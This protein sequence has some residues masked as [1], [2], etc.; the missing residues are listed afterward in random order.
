M[1]LGQRLRLG[2]LGRSNIHQPLWRQM[3]LYDCLIYSY[4]LVIINLS[5]P[6]SIP[7]RLNVALARGNFALYVV[8]NLNRVNAWGNTP[9]SSCSTQLLQRRG[10]IRS[11]GRTINVC[12]RV[13][14]EILG[15]I[16]YY[17]RLLFEFGDSLVRS[18]HHSREVQR[19]G[20]RCLD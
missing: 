20:A 8:A 1:S 3:S 17:S 7:V 4:L 14:C 2:N 16:S 12:D 11:N 15:E 19:T 9:G 5:H 6:D 10:P 13:I 18:L